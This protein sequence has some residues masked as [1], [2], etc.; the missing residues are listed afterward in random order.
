MLDGVWIILGVL[1]I[2]FVIYINK[3]KS[4][5]VSKEIR[6]TVKKVCMEYSDIKFSK[7]EIDFDRDQKSVSLN[8]YFLEDN[9]MITDEEKYQEIQKNISEMVEASLDMQVK[10]VS[11]MIEKR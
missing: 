6:T 7:C 8:L 1:L 3:N 10:E 4:I 2:I 9:K 5:K 11:M